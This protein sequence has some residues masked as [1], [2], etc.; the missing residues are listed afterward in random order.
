MRKLQECRLAADGWRSLHGDLLRSLTPQRAWEAQL[1]EAAASPLPQQASEASELSWSALL[2]RELPME[3][4]CRQILTLVGSSLAFVRRRMAEAAA[5]GA[6]VVETAWMV[7]LDAALACPLCT[8]W[9]RCLS[10]T[11]CDVT[12]LLT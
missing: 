11:A 8:I 12:F 3:G 6:S 2:G 9:C 4:L 10:M 1:R 5:R 7:R